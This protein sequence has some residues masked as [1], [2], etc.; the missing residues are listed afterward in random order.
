M[1]KSIVSDYKNAIGQKRH[2][3]IKDID[4]IVPN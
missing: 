1:Q 3:F 4:I 2:I